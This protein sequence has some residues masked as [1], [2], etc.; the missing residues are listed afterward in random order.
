MGVEFRPA[1]VGEMD[2]F[3][4]VMSYAFA[5]HRNEWPVIAAEL[6]LCAFMER[7]LVATSGAWPFTLRWNGRPA[8]AAGVTMVATAPEL[9]RRGLLRG[10][11][12]AA[13]PRFRERGQAIAVLW[14]SFGA[15]YQRF[16]FGPASHTLYYRIDPRQAGLTDP[17]PAPGRVERLAASEALG[18]IKPLYVEHATPRTLALHRGQAFWDFGILRQAEGEG[19]FAAVYRATDGAPR[20]YAVYETRMPPTHGAPNRDPELIAPFQDLVVR[21][22]VALDAEAYRGLWQYLCAHDLVRRVQMGPLPVDDPA[23]LLLA[24]PRQLRRRVNDGIW[25]RVVDVE[26][27]LAQRGYAAPGEIT[28]QVHGDPLCDWNEGTYQLEA[29]Q[30]GEVSVRRV[31]AVPDLTL[32]P[33]TL[34][35]LLAG[36]ASASELFMAG[37]L[38]AKDPA[39]LARA[40]VLFATRH[41]PHC[42]DNF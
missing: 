11:M 37:L 14:A 19:V 17:T 5:E 13:L 6:S 39:V 4:R 22:W 24:E 7:E 31:G 42:A 29:G 9:R 35:T 41:R 25:L 1:E 12:T 30:E 3:R 27:A 21:D 32:P 34:A 8:S 28:L 10:I 33:R 38:D 20:G 16:G 2:G 36:H 18:L 40:D 23:P 15:I 26:R